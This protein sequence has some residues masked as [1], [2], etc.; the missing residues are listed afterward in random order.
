MLNLSACSVVLDNVESEDLPADRE[1]YLVRIGMIDKGENVRF[2]TSGGVPFEEAG[3]LFTDVRVGSYWLPDHDHQED[4]VQS[5]LLK[6][7]TAIEFTDRDAWTY[8]DYVTV[9]PAKG[10]D[11]KV[12]LPGSDDFPERFYEALKKQWRNVNAQK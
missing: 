1:N 9:T 12:Y 5:I 11:M 7:V 10:T 8:A 4:K 6:D 3:Q 2:F